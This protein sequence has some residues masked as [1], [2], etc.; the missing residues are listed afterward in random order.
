MAT[1]NLDSIRSYRE[2]ETWGNAYRRP[3]LYEM[4]AEELVQPPF[5]REDAK[6]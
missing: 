6:R 5:V 4:L 3:R 1:F 2:R